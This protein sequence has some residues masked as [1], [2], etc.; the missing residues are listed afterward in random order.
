M[1]RV[2]NMLYLVIVPLMLLTID[3][4]FVFEEAVDDCDTFLIVTAIALHIFIPLIMYHVYQ[5]WMQEKKVL[6][7][8]S[9]LKK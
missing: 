5:E 6:K 8:Y 9:N 3:Y 4:L 2:I 1:R 7:K